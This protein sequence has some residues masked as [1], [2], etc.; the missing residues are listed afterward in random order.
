MRNKNREIFK[1]TLTSM[2]IAIAVALKYI[3]YVV[4]IFGLPILRIDIIP[5]PIIIGGLLFGPIYGGTIGILGDIIGH[6]VNPQGDYLF[7]LTINAGLIGVF[8]G[9]IKLLVKRNKKINIFILNII[10]MSFITIIGIGYIMI[11]KDIK[12]SGEI[13][14]LSF[15]I[16][17]GM[18][19]LLLLFLIVIIG[20]QIFFKIKNKNKENYFDLI[21]LVV[22]TIEITISIVISSYLFLK[23][24]GMPFWPNV[25]LRIIR[26]MFFIPIK[27]YIVNY[28]Y[29]IFKSQNI[30]IENIETKEKT[31]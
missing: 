9:L 5:I 2:L 1:L 18:I 3:S 7:G 22:V 26:A 11:A 17:L 15:N 10:L 24:W 31:F 16:K 21:F 25:L 27:V 19:L 4:P 29:L 8:A 30:F 20:S 13:Y 12:I 23:Y 14:D 6:F 28:A